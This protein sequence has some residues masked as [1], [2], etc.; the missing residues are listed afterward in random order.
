M[1]RHR[2]YFLTLSLS[3]TFTVI[4]SFYA[5]KQQDS[6][7]L[8]PHA[9]LSSL[10]QGKLGET[11][12]EAVA[13]VAKSL[14]A[15]QFPLAQRK[16]Q[17]LHFI[18]MRN[19]EM[20]GETDTGEEEIRLVVERGDTFN[21]LLQ[22]VGVDKNI[23]QRV[24][25]VIR[26]K[27]DSR[28]LTVGKPI[29]FRVRK[30]GGELQLLGL[31]FKPS[32]EQNL[33]LMLDEQGAYKVELIK[34]A[35]RKV[36][37][38]VDGVVG[39]SFYAAAMA[40][41]VPE[42]TVRDAVKALSYEIDWQRDPKAGSAFEIVYEAFEDDEGN[43]V[44]GELHYVAFAPNRSKLCRMY[45][46]K[47]Q[48]ISSSIGY[49][50]ASGESLVKTFLRTPLDPSRMK[51][52][53]SK[54]STRATGGKGRFHPIL[55]YTRDH[56]GTDYAAPTGTDVYAA[57]DGKVIE[58]RYDGGYGKKVVIQH[59]G[60]YKTVYAHLSVINV[61]PGEYVKQGRRVGG[62]GRT[63][64]ATGPHLHHEVIYKG[65]HVDPQKVVPKMP[66]IKLT[67]KELKAFQ[68]LRQKIDRYVVGVAPHSHLVLRPTAMMTDLG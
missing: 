25:H 18:A 13:E 68:Q 9:Q 16:D 41:G 27:F 2:L 63:G 5:Y 15:V 28:N 42:S 51:R 24:T 14:Q 38:H 48:G 53:S 55:G 44:R 6:A 23:A 66:A 60:D 58:A 57:G 61:K 22:R 7:I 39:S 43:L 37:R 4:M 54:F 49:Y 46:W 33:H 12:T 36:M 11:E 21:I 52:V 30:K 3:L 45:R 59:A 40:R 17:E 31:S 10:M 67:G 29:T 1:Q 56:K 62:V 19:R 26:T 34:V 20:Y 32:A 64:T 35:L 65:K 50:N 47:S 8:L